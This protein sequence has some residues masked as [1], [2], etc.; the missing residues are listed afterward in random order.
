MPQE[1]MIMRETAPSY[2][3]PLFRGKFCLNGVIMGMVGAVGLET[4]SN[5]FHPYLALTLVFAKDGLKLVCLSILSLHVNAILHHLFPTT[6]RLDQLG[7][8]QLP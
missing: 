8:K 3:C 6:L 4:Q 5:I 1:L 2:L 7:C